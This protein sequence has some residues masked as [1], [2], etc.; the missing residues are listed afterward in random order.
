VAVLGALAPTRLRRL[1]PRRTVAMPRLR[2][3]AVRHANGDRVAAFIEFAGR[4]LCECVVG[5]KLRAGVGRD[6]G[7]P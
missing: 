6:A 5:T 2:R 4:V 3:I 7:A 1:A